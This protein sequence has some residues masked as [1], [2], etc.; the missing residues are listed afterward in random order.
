M[1][2]PGVQKPAA[3]MS[4]AGLRR[5]EKIVHY[6]DAPG[7]SRRKTRIKL[8]EPER[9][10]VWIKRNEDDRFVVADSVAQ[11]RASQIE[12]GRLLVELPVSVKQRSDEIEIFRGGLADPDLPVLGFQEHSP[13]PELELRG[14]L[15]LA[16]ADAGCA[17]ANA[18]TRAADNR[19]HRLQVYIPAPIRNIVG[20][21]NLMPELRPFAANI[22]NSCHWVKNSWGTFRSA[23]NHAR[24]QTSV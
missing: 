23:P 21:A 20:M 10:S 16:V 13:G 4:A 9:R 8:C 6:E 11:E 12:V 22:A 7:E 15:N 5:H 2:A 19:P 17:R 14:F 18:L 3:N 1:A 24:T